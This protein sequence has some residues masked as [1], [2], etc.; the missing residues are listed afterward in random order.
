MND[1]NKVHAKRFT[2][3]IELIGKYV[4]YKSKILDVGEE[5]EITKHCRQWG[6]DVST[7]GGQDVT[8]LDWVH[9]STYYDCVLCCEV[10]E[11]LRDDLAAPRDHYT[12]T[13]VKNCLRECYRVLK[14]GGYLIATTPN[15]CGLVNIQHL[16]YHKHPFMYEPHLREMT[17]DE[18]SAFVEEQNF[19]IVEHLFE[20][21]WGDHGMGK[22]FV[23]RLEIFMRQMGVSLDRRGSCQMIVARK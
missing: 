16:L 13:G 7:T 3:T 12:A 8:Q 9:P 1:Y 2:R 10:L 21:V 22:E 20:D 19:T 23:K 5:S 15:V 6:H 4:N 14:P 17:P 11:H 18:F